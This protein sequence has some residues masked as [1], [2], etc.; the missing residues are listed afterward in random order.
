MNQEGK[1]CRAGADI[2]MYQ[3]FNSTHAIQQL[4]VQAEKPIAVFSRRRTSPGARRRQ[5]R[6]LG[7]LTTLLFYPMEP[8]NGYYHR[9]SILKINQ[10]NLIFRN[11]RSKAITL[12]LSYV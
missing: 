1:L 12:A 7:E 3:P 6:F 2:S 4:I 11:D 10:L 9:I 5:K 8:I